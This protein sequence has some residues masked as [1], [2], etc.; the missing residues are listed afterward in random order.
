MNIRKCVYEN[1]RI[2]E[3]RSVMGKVFGMTFKMA[4]L[5]AMKFYTHVIIKTHKYKYLKM[6]ITLV[7]YAYAT[8][9]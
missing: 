1:G 8:A 4:A 6:S 7:I 2:W 9:N 5:N 3:C